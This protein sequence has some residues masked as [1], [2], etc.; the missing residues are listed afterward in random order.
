MVTEC[1]QVNVPN[2][3]PVA[4][5]FF[6]KIHARRVGTPRRARTQFSCRESAELDGTG[7]A[8]TGTAAALSVR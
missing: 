5:K 1:L 7:P 2:G 3:L 6:A 8:L 4:R